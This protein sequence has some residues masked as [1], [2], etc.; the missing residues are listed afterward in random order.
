MLFFDWLVIHHTQPP[1]VLCS[2]TCRFWSGPST[3]FHII[4]G[5]SPKRLLV[6]P[7]LNTT[8]MIFILLYSIRCYIL[9]IYIF[10]IS[11]SVIC[12]HHFL[13]SFFIPSSTHLT[14]WWRPWRTRNARGWAFRT[15][16]GWLRRLS[17]VGG[18]LLLLIF[19]EVFFSFKYID[20]LGEVFFK[21]WLILIKIWFKKM[22]F[23][24]IY[25]LTLITWILYIDV[26]SQ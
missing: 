21:C 15:G 20:F 4:V 16:C 6:T 5:R 2:W 13:S 10:I 9:Y 18:C 14:G 17:W 19:G 7:H 25:P 12:S 8:T 22:V 3:E 1:M 24:L 26:N 11:I 23:V